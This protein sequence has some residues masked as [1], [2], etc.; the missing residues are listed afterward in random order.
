MEEFLKRVV[1]ANRLPTRIRSTLDR[2]EALRD[3]DY[4]INMIQVGGVDAFRVDYEVP[5]Q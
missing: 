1:K 3:A 2:K 4:V 5:M